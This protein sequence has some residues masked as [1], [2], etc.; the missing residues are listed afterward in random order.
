MN[1]LDNIKQKL[2]L[3]QVKHVD[4][5]ICSLLSFERVLD[6][7]DTGTGKTY[8]SIAACCVLGKNHSLYAPIQ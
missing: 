3:Y 6:A 2:L 5:L 1:V 4:N 7:Y 8:T